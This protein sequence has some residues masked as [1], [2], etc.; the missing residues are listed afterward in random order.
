MIFDSR[1]GLDVEEL[2]ATDGGTWSGLLFDNPRIGIAPQLTWRFILPY[3]DVARAYGQ[4]S[5]ALT[6]EWIALQVS[7]WR[8]MRG[9]TARCATFGDCGEASVY[10]FSHHRYDCIDLEITDQR[11]GGAG[12][13]QAAVSGDIDRLG[14]E[15]IHAEAWLRF[16]RDCRRAQRGQLGAGCSVS[17]G[18]FR[19]HDWPDWPDWDVGRAAHRV[20][21]RRPQVTGVKWSRC[22]SMGAHTVVLCLVSPPLCLRRLGQDLAVGGRA[23]WRGRLGASRLRRGHRR[24][25]RHG[26]R[27]RARPGRCAECLRCRATRYRR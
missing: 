5:V 1:N 26:S 15:E 4:T 2:V 14:R 8:G 20:Q 12:H 21:V 17:P 11:E 27:S 23:R 16:E 3:E 24:R 13:V 9:H 22:L 19:R 7:S 18:G 10:F 6:V 25:A